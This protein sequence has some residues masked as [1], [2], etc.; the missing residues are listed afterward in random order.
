MTVDSLWMLCLLLFLDG[1]TTAAFTT[2]LLLAYAK[3]FEPWQVA[4][5]GG[6]ASAAGSV[7]QLAIFR[8]MLGHERPWMGRFL[9]SKQ[10]LEETLKRYPSA[11][12]LAIAVAR[13]TPLPDAPLKLVAAA[14]GY[15]LERYFV[16]VLTGAL[17]YY[18]LLAWAG[19]ELPIP[20]WLIAAL[21]GVVAI[22]FVVDLIRKSRA[23]PR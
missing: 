4:L 15:P 8:W 21:F 20:P 23:A 16:A 14:I 9:P 5:A 6:A 7:V 3:A 10:K 1:A 12:F 22:A 13:A 19:H 18:A 17:P 2:P 11:S